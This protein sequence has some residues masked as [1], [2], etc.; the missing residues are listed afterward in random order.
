MNSTAQ[1]V[2]IFLKKNS[3]NTN[4]SPTLVAN[5]MKG[6]T[7]KKADRAF[8]FDNYPSRMIALRLAYH[9]H[10][11]DG[12]AKQEET[13]NTVEGIVCEALKRLRLIPESGP[14]KFGRCGRTDKGVSA[15]GNVFSLKAR[16]SSWPDDPVQKPPLD[17]G[18]MLNNSLPPTIRIVGFSYVLDDFDARFSCISRT[19]RYYFAHGG[20]NLD[21]MARAAGYFLGT[22]NFR[23]FCKVDVV[24]VSNFERHVS[25]VGIYRSEYL[26][27]VISF[28]EITA[29]SFLYHQIRCTMEV[30]FL[31]GRG[32]ESPEVVRQL[33]ER[34]DE[35]PVYPLADATPLILWDCG[36]KDLRWQFSHRAF[37]LVEHELQDICT[38]LL[39][40]ATTAD[41]MRRQ[42]FTWYHGLEDCTE[43]SA[44]PR[45]TVRKPCS[46]VDEAP[47]DA[48]SITGCD[49]TEPHTHENLKARKSD[50]YRLMLCEDELYNR[51]QQQRV[52][53]EP[54][55]TDRGTAS[56]EMA[57]CGPQ[58]ISTPLLNYVPLL[59]R[60]TVRTYEEQ[61][62]MLT[63]K[64]RARYEL[65][66]AKKAVGS[67]RNA[68][69]RQ[70]LEEE[71]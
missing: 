6:K 3:Q 48:W 22:H 8:V 49:W 59:E 2:G 7:R 54:L 9:G 23:N 10:V 56:G 29:N 4:A 33:L 64:K 37:Q 65:N 41:A 58:W 42:L 18:H 43:A 36:F 70:T 30:L 34:G 50:L 35:K 57:A 12:L 55:H 69:K 25:S 47:M 62:G 53:S 13:A 52:S 67:K 14:E 19:Y 45:L 21:A 32:L 20:L 31:V 27:E 63:G 11:H 24:N 40:R 38:A 44:Q 60:E 5:R 46:A 66:E 51:Q 26:P 1:K 71:P 28:F 68:E 61:V 17:Y 15:L 16:A 39:I